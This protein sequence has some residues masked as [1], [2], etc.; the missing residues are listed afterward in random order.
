[1]IIQAIGRALG[2]LLLVVLVVACELFIL[3]Q[4]EEADFRFTIRMGK[5][6]NRIGRELKE[7]GLEE[8]TAQT[9]K[10]A[11]NDVQQNVQSYVNDKLNWQ[12]FFL[13][14]LAPIV[15]VS[16]V[17]STCQRTIQKT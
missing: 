1:M 15:V 16:W 12:F 10:Y 11:L 2:L 17:A 13:T 4:S 8:K 14:I 6:I 9:I 7:T 5:D 3:H